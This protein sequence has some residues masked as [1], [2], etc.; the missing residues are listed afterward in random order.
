MAGRLSSEVMGPAHRAKVIA[1]RSTRTRT[2]RTDDYVDDDVDDD[3][4]RWM[5][6]VSGKRRREERLKLE[7]G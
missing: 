1:S 3:L 5:Q 2:A 6:G 7:T 4:V